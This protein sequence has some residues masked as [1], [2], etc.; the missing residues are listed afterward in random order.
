MGELTKQLKSHI[1]EFV[2][3]VLGIATS[4][5]RLKQLFRVPLYSNALYLMLANVYGALL[6]FVFWI[7]VTRLYSPQDV[8]LA[9]AGISAM[10]LLATISHLGLGTGLIRFLARS[11]RNASL[12]INTVFS[13]GTLTSIAA[14]LIFIAGLGLWS[15]ALLFIRD[16]P[17]Y[18]IAFVFF[19]IAF[20][21][22]TL[23]GQAF[24]AERRAGF[25]LANT[26]I[27]NLLKLLLPALLAIFLNAF[28]IIASWGI[29]L[30][31]AF[32]VSTFLFLPRVR[33]GYRPRF[34]I[35][36]RIT[37][38]I[39]PFSFINYLSGLLWGAPVLILPLI[40]VNL[41]GAEPNAFFYMAWAI[42]SV[43][44]MVPTA[45]STSL[46][47]EGSYEEEKLGSNIR[48][49]LKM[50]LLLLVPAIILIEIFA[51]K[52]LLVF[53]SSYSE[54]AADLLRIL[55]ATALPLT[56][57]T[58][59][60]AVK[61]VEGKL[62]VIIGLSA[63]V[64]LVTIGLAYPL[65]NIMDINGVGIA[66]LAAQ[67]VAALVIGISLLLKRM[68]ARESSQRNESS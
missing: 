36:R 22:S 9:S 27:F 13:I 38:K 43:L 42:G 34:A 46:F 2:A 7:I 29:P 18:F 62:K 26:L 20:T 55:A 65:L 39:M 50:A 41:L 21:L 52:L 1:N 10:G 28:G 47:A 25:T 63:F 40:V 51:D 32:L 15:P 54:N 60:I 44:N 35:S 59:Y 33:T 37:K 16:D 68:P 66:W 17:L 23:I 12:M 67:V 8:G 5:E 58:I 64:G 30:V 53:G 57:N 3:D 11:G 4:R 61:R 6:G 49:S 19:T 31:I 56:V 14:A 48:R 24:V 45:I